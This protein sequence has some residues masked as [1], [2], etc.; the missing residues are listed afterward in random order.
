MLDKHQ[1]QKKDSFVREPFAVYFQGNK[2]SERT[3]KK[4]KK[5]T[6]GAG[7]H[8]D[9]ALT[10]SFSLFLTEIEKFILVALHTEPGKVV[11]E[12]DRL[13]DVFKEVSKKWNNEVRIFTEIPGYDNSGVKTTEGG[14]NCWKMP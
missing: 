2:T 9:Q 3:L 4:K 14:S 5:H 12:I 8:R 10:L 6:P 1:Y 11:Q 7:N 13:Y